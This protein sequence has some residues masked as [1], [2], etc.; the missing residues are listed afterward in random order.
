MPYIEQERREAV[1]E[2]GPKN[3]GELNYII[4]MCMHQYVM[5]RPFTYQ[6][7]SEAV[8]AARDAADEFVRTV[9][10][11]YEDLKRKENGYISVLDNEFND[12]Q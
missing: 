11:P 5:E 4:T 12:G 10:A 8:A 7:L 6:V 9:L 3:K 1:F 2:E